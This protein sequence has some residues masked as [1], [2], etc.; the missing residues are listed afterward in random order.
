MLVATTQASNSSSYSFEELR[1][2]I[3]WEINPNEVHRLD[4]TVLGV[5]SFGSVYRATWHGI[6]VAVKEIDLEITKSTPHKA[7]R[8]FIQEMMIW[9]SLKFPSVV[10]LYGG[11]M[12]PRLAMVMQ[13]C[14][15]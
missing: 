4:S 6:Q 10:Q 13:Y 7:L 8:D 15:G 1:L 11:Y 14:A 2:G 12:K 5:G 9:K 3:D